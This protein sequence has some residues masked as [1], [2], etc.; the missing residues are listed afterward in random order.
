MAAKFLIINTTTGDTTE[1]LAIDASVGASDAN[2]IVST[3]PDG[4]LAKSLLALEALPAS[5]RIAAADRDLT[6]AVP[7]GAA[8]KLWTDVQKYGPATTSD[9]GD[10]TKGHVG[11]YVGPA[12]PATGDDLDIVT[13]GLTQVNIPTA[14]TVPV[15]APLTYTTTGELKER[16]PG[17]STP[18]V[19]FFLRLLSGTQSEIYVVPAFMPEQKEYE[20]PMQATI[21]APSSNFLLAKRVGGKFIWDEDT[22]VHLIRVSVKVG[23]PATGTIILDT[24][25]S[26]DVPIFDSFLVPGAGPDEY[27]TYQ[28]N[29]I[30][31]ANTLL[32]TGEEVRFKVD[33]SSSLDGSNPTFKFLLETDVRL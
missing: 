2:R 8:I 3:G 24:T 25:F 21:D 13:S 27:G 29:L 17:E 26:D 31:N 22:P 32:T 30:A 19:A 12:N 33:A 16:L 11:I 9:T 4:R 28:E 5:Y 10:V 18:V 14:A 15:G 23:I 7:N 6:S 1:Q 20:I